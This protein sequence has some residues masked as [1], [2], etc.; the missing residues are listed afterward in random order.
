MWY[1]IVPPIIVVASLSFVLWYFSR[2]GAD[3]LIAEKASRLGEEGSA[4]D[5]FSAHESFAVPYPGEDRFPVQGPVARMHNALH[6]FTQTIKARQRR[7]QD[8]AAVS[9]EAPRVS[10][11][12]ERHTAGIGFFRRV[13]RDTGAAADMPQPQHPL[14]ADHPSGYVPE[15]GNDTMTAVEQGAVSAAVLTAPPAAQTVFATLEENVRPM[16][17]ETMAHP[18][19]PRARTESDMRR[20]EE[21]IARIAG[22][23]KDFAAYEGLGDHYLDIGNI[24]DAKECYRQ[25][26]KLSPA[27]RMVKIKIR[28]LE[29][30]FSEQQPM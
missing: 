21:L 29:K 28:R 8:K 20:E 1:L 27:H 18:E 3:P 5:I 15:Q 23:P 24:R 25:V 26:L 10:G 4:A 30:L 11:R 7:F 19:K 12:E 9:T 22:N 14:S 17:S 6:D 13:T 2:K 16:V